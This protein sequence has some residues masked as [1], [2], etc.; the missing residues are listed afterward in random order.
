MARSNHDKV[1]LKN[2][3][4]ELTT[5]QS[6][7]IE[8][9]ETTGEDSGDNAFRWR[10]GPD[11]CGVVV[12]RNSGRGFVQ[13]TGSGLK[14]QVIQTGPEESGFTM[15]GIASGQTCMIYGRSTVLYIRPK[16]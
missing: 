11:V 8:A 12:D 9:D 15:A 1:R 7:D 6:V 16:T 3:A 10:V 14:D 5:G 2:K 4:E 13:I